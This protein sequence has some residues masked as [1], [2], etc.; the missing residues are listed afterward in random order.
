MDFHGESLLALTR[1]RELLTDC[2]N[3]RNFHQLFTP[4][5][6]LKQGTFASVYLVKRNCDGKMFAAKAF[7]KEGLYGRKYGKV[8]TS[9][10][11]GVTHQLNQ[12]HE[13]VP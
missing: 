5:R 10:I 12:N 1:W 7:S 8:P 3:Q 4:I 13:T 11:S 6:K 2:M 9:L